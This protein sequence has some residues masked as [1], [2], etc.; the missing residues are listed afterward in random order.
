M[1]DE[2]ERHN[3][4]EDSGVGIGENTDGTFNTF[5]LKDLAAKTQARDLAE[6]ETMLAMQEVAGDDKGTADDDDL[7]DLGDIAALADA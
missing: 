7:S 3:S 5:P 1:A 6:M 4:F 2:K